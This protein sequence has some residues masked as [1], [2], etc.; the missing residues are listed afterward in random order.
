MK[1]TFDSNAWERI[2][3]SEEQYA[4]IIASIDSRRVEGF[5]CDAAFRIEAI[6]KRDRSNYFS[7]PHMGVGF[8]VE[9][10]ADGLVQLFSVGPA[11]DHH[12]GLPEPQATKLTLALA[13][14]VKLIRSQNW[15]GLPMPTEVNSL[16]DYVAEDYQTCRAREQ[17]QIDV[18]QLID[19]CGLGH[20]SFLNVGGWEVRER[21]MKEQKALAK[22]CAEWADGELVAAHIAYG[23]NILC[24]DDRAVQAGRSIFDAEH[25]AWLADSLGVVFISLDELTRQLSG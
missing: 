15:M 18:S 23:H 3:A 20:A 8:D 1:I 14:G 12:P 10:R 6:R 7:T 9:N 2:F 4:A 16:L 11:N 5:I 24:T 19:D 21:S 13:S 25:R 22:A 17:R